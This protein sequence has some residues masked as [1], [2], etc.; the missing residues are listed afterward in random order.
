MN[1]FPTVEQI[2]MKDCPTQTLM[3]CTGI[4]FRHM[5]ITMCVTA[6]F[7]LLYTTFNGST[8]FIHVATYVF[9]IN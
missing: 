8:C 9:Y 2:Y 6:L 4:T 1:I 3:L 5:A 7:T